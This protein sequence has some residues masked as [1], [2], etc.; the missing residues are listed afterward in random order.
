MQVDDLGAG[1]LQ[2]QHL[3]VGA[4][5]EDMEHAH[6]ERGELVE[7]LLDCWRDQSAFG[8]TIHVLFLPHRRTTRKVRVF[9]DYLKAHLQAEGLG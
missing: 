8:P 1:L 7:Q 3:G 9:I 6:L 2:A 4:H 5:R